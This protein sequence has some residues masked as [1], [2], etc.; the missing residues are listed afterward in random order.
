[1]GRGGGSSSGGGGGGGGGSSAASNTT[2]SLP[3]ILDQ[4]FPATHFKYILPTAMFVVSAICVLCF[5]GF[6]V[7]YAGIRAKNKQTKK[8]LRWA[9]IGFSIFLMT[10]YFGLDVADRVL[11]ELGE[12]RI[13]MHWPFM[14]TLEALSLFGDVMLMT[15]LLVPL[16]RELSDHVKIPEQSSSFTIL[17]HKGLNYILTGLATA[18]IA[19][20]VWKLVTDRFFDEDF[21]E[22]MAESGSK[23]MMILAAYTKLNVAFYGLYFAGAISITVIAMRALMR[24]R[25]AG[26]L[27]R[28]FLICLPLLSA[29]VLVRT[30]GKFI[31]AIVFKLQARVQTSSTQLIHTIFYGLLSVV[32]YATILVIA[33]SDDWESDI[34]PV[35][36]NVEY[37]PV[38]YTSYGETQY[39]TGEVNVA[40]QET[41]LMG[42]VDQGYTYNHRN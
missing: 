10:L 5:I 7:W 24:L 33:G 18:N 2:T 4:K 15:F 25:K 6:I 40:V 12:K 13:L 28:T 29:S 20:F 11:L 32:I 3:S 31:Y 27:R 36:A 30:L 37:G 39:K 34:G 19:A 16:A 38:A 35:R 22:A 9:V 23:P 17:C 26:A 41:P 1:M 14:I 42:H 8:L 21:R